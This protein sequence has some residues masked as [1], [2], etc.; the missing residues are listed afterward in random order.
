LGAIFETESIS[1]RKAAAPD[2]CKLTSFT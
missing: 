2:A 1:I